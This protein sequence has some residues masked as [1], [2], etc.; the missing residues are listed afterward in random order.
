MMESSRTIC[1]SLRG[2]CSLL[3][4]WLLWATPQCDS[5]RLVAVTESCAS[6]GTCSLERTCHVVGESCVASEDCCSGACA[7]NGKRDTSGTLLRTCL[8]LTGCRSLGEFCLVNEECCS[9]TCQLDEDGV[10]SHCQPGPF[11]CLQPGEY[12]GNQ[13]QNSGLQCCQT[14]NGGAGEPMDPCIES[15]YGVYRCRKL[16]FTCKNAG[17]ECASSS[18]CCVASDGTA[19]HFCLPDGT[20]KTVCA[21]TCS[22]LGEHCRAAADCCMSPELGP[23]DC[24]DETCSLSGVSCN[25]VGQLCGTDNCCTGY[26][27]E[28]AMRIGD[29]PDRICS[30]R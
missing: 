17:E 7:E 27:R 18:E 2:A 15:Y 14:N 8:S 5:E 16:M 22:R 12:C 11:S 10:G 4:L 19:G 26:C 25:Q 29:A 9:K 13:A 3:A 28:N 24:I 1:S 21:Q 20:G 6:T 30:V 23:V